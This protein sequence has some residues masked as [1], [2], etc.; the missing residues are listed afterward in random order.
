MYIK[1]SGLLEIAFHYLV[2]RLFQVIR[3]SS[4]AYIH[5]DINVSRHT[6]V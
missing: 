5:I 6:Y 1:G 3:F 2:L 4:I